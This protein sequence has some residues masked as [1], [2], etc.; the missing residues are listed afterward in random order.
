M[1]KEGLLSKSVNGVMWTSID[2]LVNKVGLFLASLYIA[3]LLGPEV[4]G[5]IGMISIFINIG[6][7]LVDSGMSMSLIRSPEIN[8]V[9]MSSVFLGSL[10]I[11]LFVYAAFYFAAP[12]I[13]DFYSQ[14]VLTNVVRIY[15]LIFIVSAFRSVQSALLS[16]ELKF[17]KNTMIALP[18]II[19]AITCGIV[20]AH[21]GAG[22]WS[23]VAM[24]LVQ[25]F[26][27]ALLL[28]SLSSW[29]LKLI[30]SK[31]A[32]KKHFSFGYKVTMTGMLNNICNNVNNVLIGRFYPLRLSGYYE[33]AFSLNQIPAGVFTAMVS[34]VA[35]PALAKI[36]HD[37]M[38]VVNAFRSLV[39]YV[40]LVMTFIMLLMIVFA[41]ELIFILLGNQWVNIVPYLQLI[42][43]AMVF[44]PVHILN[45]N[46]LFVFGKSNLA[47]RAEIIKKIFQVMFALIL[48]KFGVFWLVSSLI[49][50]SVVELFV[51]AYFVNKVVPFGVKAQLSA[52]RNPLL[53]FLS[54]LTISYFIKISSGGGDIWISIVL[55]LGILVSYALFIFIYE[56]KN[57]QVFRAMMKK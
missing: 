34:K 1:S 16:R 18:A 57:L 53:L 39:K 55:L 4:Y 12:F 46:L 13:A 51:N 10:L 41:D 35:T 43:L 44:L 21:K 42:S 20:L 40:F 8:K 29:R 3:R 54:L 23:I 15:C 26:I 38:K 22:V 7:S 11:S 37:K 24:Y 45:A 31:E 48:F 9:D 2:I 5:L 28:W 56:R 25:Q 49:F 30:F 36:Q 32:F 6:N 17:K 50:G 14:P 47:L 27:L 19:I 52:I 33:R